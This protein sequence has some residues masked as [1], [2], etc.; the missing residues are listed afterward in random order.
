MLK[1]PTAFYTIASQLVADIDVA[2]ADSLGGR[3]E[4]ACV[5]PGE[6]AWDECDCG[7]L[8]VTVRRWN[9]SDGFP[10]ESDTRG[11]LRIGPCDLPWI[12][13]ELHIQIVRCAPSPNNNALSVPCPRLDAAAEVLISDAYTVINQTI[14]TLCGYKSDEEIVDYQVGE[15]ETIGPDGGCVGSVVVVQVSI[16]R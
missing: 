13:G 2:L 15:Q 6:V 8:A 1:G 9:L 4:R 11:A 5:V 12:V 7:M 10:G 3:P 16:D 14:I